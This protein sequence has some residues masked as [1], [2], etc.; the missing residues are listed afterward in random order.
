MRYRLWDE[1][2]SRAAYR[3]PLMCSKHQ[4]PTTAHGIPSFGRHVG[5]SASLPH[6]PTQDRAR[7]LQSSS[8][9]FGLHPWLGKAWKDRGWLGPG[10]CPESR[11][12]SGPRSRVEDGSRPIPGPSMRA[13]PQPVASRVSGPPVM[14]LTLLSCSTPLSTAIGRDKISPTK[15]RD[16]Q[17]L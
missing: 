2:C 5:G 7:I 17:R 10:V 6:A 3:S 4:H 15:R 16:L 12:E 14:G 9:I 8:G 1:R 11:A 13:R